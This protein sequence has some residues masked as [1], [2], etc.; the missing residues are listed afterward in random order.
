[1]KRTVSIKVIE[2]QTTDFLFIILIFSVSLEPTNPPLS[3][4]EIEQSSINSKQLPADIRLNMLTGVPLT[5]SKSRS[6]TSSTSTIG[7]RSKDALDRINELIR[8][9]S[10]QD[11][12][13]KNTDDVFDDHDGLLSSNDFNKRRRSDGIS[14]IQFY[15]NETNK[16]TSN[17]ENSI[18]EQFNEDHTEQEKL[19]ND[20][21]IQQV[22]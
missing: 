8:Q 22:N 3:K 9:N 6:L 12:E 13:M 19:S 11:V 10:V 16:L 20:A 1:M 21:D 15:I 4:P 2:K 18:Q 5:T 7:E 14:S 17:L